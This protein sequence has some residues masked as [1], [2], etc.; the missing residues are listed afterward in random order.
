MPDVS[1]M[2]FQGA[3]LGATMFSDVRTS[4]D[5][6]KAMEEET[7][8]WELMREERAA[9]A[10]REQDTVVINDFIAQ[11]NTL[12]WWKANGDSPEKIG[13]SLAFINAVR[14]R[15]GLA[16]IE[17]LTDIRKPMAAAEVSAAMQAAIVDP[18]NGELTYKLMTMGLRD[19]YGDKFVDGLA[20]DAYKQTIISERASREKLRAEAEARLPGQSI[21]TPLKTEDAQQTAQVANEFIKA[22]GFIPS[23]VS[24][25]GKLATSLMQSGIMKQRAAKPSDLPASLQAPL[26]ELP[27]NATAEDRLMYTL[28]VARGRMDRKTFENKL[29]T[30]NTSTMSIAQLR[31][32]IHGADEAG[33]ISAPKIEVP[34]LG[35]GSTLV[36][37]E[38]EA[39][40]QFMTPDRY[41]EYMQQKRNNNMAMAEKVFVALDGIWKMADSGVPVD[42]IKSSVAPMLGVINE[43]AKENGFAVMTENQ[44]LRGVEDA[45][46]RAN[47]RKQREE[48][49]AG[50]EISTSVANID[51]I[52]SHAELNR[53]QA[54]HLGRGGGGGGGGGWGGG[55]MYMAGDDDITLGA[56]PSSVLNTA[57]N[58]KTGALN[59]AKVNY[60]GR[61]YFTQIFGSADVSNSELTK[62][63][64]M[65]MS[66][67]TMSLLTFNSQSHTGLA[68]SELNA[69]VT[70]SSN[71]SLALWVANPQLQKALMSSDERTAN[72]AR[73]QVRSELSKGTLRLSRL[74]SA[75]LDR[76]LAANVVRVTNSNGYS[77]DSNVYLWA[78]DKL[79]ANAGKATNKPAPAGEDKKNDGTTTNKPAPAGKA[80][81]PYTV[82]HKRPS[83][84]IENH[85]GGGYSGGITS[86]GGRVYNA[87]GVQIK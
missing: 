8:R 87:K 37:D 28:K 74:G 27:E 75:N 22:T 66:K 21:K 56:L 80:K 25:E 3:K 16:P 2:F 70:T 12:A 29:D 59:P 32:L 50:L 54:R 24:L 41:E 43:Y 48:V 34:L 33:V 51:L 77:T 63:A 19:K 36:I 11:T 84:K 83:Q 76:N 49:A 53:A 9:A 82:T 38:P 45:V 85:A 62:L 14:Q 39:M 6:I 18:I 40:K 72:A 52:R 13:Q 58:P 67:D 79:T 26:E 86:R 7:R 15:N 65:G 47:R 57:R 20:A 55:G 10:Q 69:M 1:E 81:K 68:M 64:N 5:R 44:L 71:K 35:G 46:A 78:Q 31:K 23:G 60:I 4:V 30:A 42:S 17:G 61:Q 73:A